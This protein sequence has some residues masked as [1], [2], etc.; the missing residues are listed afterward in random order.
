MKGHEEPEKENT[1]RWLLTY[2]DLI[3]LLLA[4]FIILFSMSNVDKEKYAALIESLGSVFGAVQGTAAP[5]NGAGGEIN[6]PIFSPGTSVKPSLN[7]MHSPGASGMSETPLATSSPNNG[8][9]GNAI[10]IEAQRMEDV[11]NQVQGFLN[12]ENLQGDVTVS[13]RQRGLV[14]S[15]NSRVLFASG[16][17]ELTKESSELVKRI[18]SILTPLAN[19][20]ICVEGHTDTVPIHTYQFPSNWHLSAGRALSVLKLL[21]DSNPKLIPENMSFIGYGEYRPI[22]PND[23][24]ANKAKNRRVNIVIL[25]DEFNKS[26]DISPKE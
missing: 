2:S 10:D 6:F 25:K 17:A 4:L 13:I 22:A 7:P 19:N 21:L 5:G 18:A 20:Q 8:G 24:E 26:I 11:K 16:K 1:E 12:D 9:I 3:T 15:I 23:T 14:I